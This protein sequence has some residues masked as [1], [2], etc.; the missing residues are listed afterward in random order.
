VWIAIALVLALVRRRWELF[1]FVVA[2][3]A[4]A[5]LLASLLK[6]VFD[7][8]RPPLVYPEPRPLVHDPATPSFPSGHA[9]TSFACAT[10]LSLAFPRATPG[11]FVLAA[12]IAYS[13]VYVGVHWPADVIAGALLGVVVAAVLAL[14][15]ARRRRHA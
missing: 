1:V 8:R 7:R 9:A 2:A 5:Q 6:D 13:R 15:V 4:V 14:A 10:M 11:F 3:D 12:A